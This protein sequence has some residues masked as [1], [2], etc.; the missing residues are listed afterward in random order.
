M[1]T[2]DVLALHLELVE[3]PHVILEVFSGMPK[4]QT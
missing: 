2:L 4:K 3:A 1:E